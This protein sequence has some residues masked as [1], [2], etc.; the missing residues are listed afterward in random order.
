MVGVDGDLFLGWLISNL[1]LSDCLSFRKESQIA[2]RIQNKSGN[3][4]QQ[5]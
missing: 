2:S 4:S 5:R 3:Y 1:A